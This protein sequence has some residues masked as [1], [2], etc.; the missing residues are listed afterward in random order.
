MSDFGLSS[1]CQ[2]RAQAKYDAKNTA[3]F[4]LKLNYTTDRDIIE[5]ILKQSSYQGA[6][7]KL[8]REELQRIQSGKWD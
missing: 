6:I 2:K 4:S 1:A 7:K 8:V 3:H 5:W